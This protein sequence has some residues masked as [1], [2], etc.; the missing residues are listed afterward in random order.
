MLTPLNSHWNPSKSQFGIPRIPTTYMAAPVP[1]PRLQ[2]PLL[3]LPRQHQAPRQFRRLPSVISGV[4]APN[5]VFLRDVIFAFIYLCYLKQCRPKLLTS[6][7]LLSDEDLVAYQFEI[8]NIAGWSTDEGAALHKQENGC[9]ALTFWTWNDATSSESAY[10][11]FN[12]PF[13]IKSG[14]VERAIVS[15]GGP[16]LSCQGKGTE[17]PFPKRALGPALPPPELT[18]EKLHALQ[19]I[20][21]NDTSSFQSYV[22]MNWTTTNLL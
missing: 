7:L 19:I 16:K 12:L 9:G 17:F 10:V 6:F 4:S 13:F 5:Q 21:G 15:A 14:C 20:Y 18:T 22:P 1:L 11:Y 3:Q 2:L 8:F